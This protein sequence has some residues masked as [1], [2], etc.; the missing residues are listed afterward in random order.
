MAITENPEVQPL[1]IQPPPPTPSLAAKLEHLAAKIWQGLQILAQ[2]PST[3]LLPIIV[4]A[5]CLGIW[6]VFSTFQ[7]EGGL[8]GPTQV[9]ADTKHLIL[10]PWYVK[11]ANDQGIGRH[12]LKSLS[13]VGLGYL[14]AVILGTTIG[15]LIGASQ[16]LY[17]GFDPLFQVLRTVAPLAWLPIAQLIFKQAEPSAIFLIFITA[18]WPIIINTAVGVQQ[19]PQ[20]YRNIARVLQLSKVQAFWN[21][22]LPSAAPYIF[23]GL[24][25]AVGLSWLAIVAAEMVT[26]GVGIGSYIWDRY[27]DGRISNV[28]VSIVYVGLVGLI[29]DKIVFYLSKVTVQSET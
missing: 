28:I 9:L 13:R 14:L 17:K 10:N 4:L 19:V 20:D 15:I 2:D 24:R 16:L 23:T 3:I 5:A 26:G 22:I 25:I 6:Q 27:N 8:P 29:L 7:G 1:S 18:I 12:I 11:N 21:I